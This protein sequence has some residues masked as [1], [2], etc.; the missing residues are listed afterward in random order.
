MSGGFSSLNTALTALRYNRVAMDVAGS[1]IA[2]VTTDGYAR[3]RVEGAAVAGPTQPALWSRY[4]GA[5]DGVQVTGVTRMTDELLNVRARREHGNQAYLD[6]RQASLENIENG[7]GEPGDSGV[8]AALADLRNA[9]HELS[10][11]PGSQSARAQVLSSA[12]SVVDAIG[13]QARNVESEAGDQRVHVLNDVSEVNTVASG[14]ADT[15]R[16]IAAGN[17][18]GSDVGVLLDKRDQLTQRL[19]E[20]TGAKATVRSDGGADVTINGVP[21]VTG[22]RAGSLTVASGITP[23]GESDGTALTF[24]V[25]DASGATT[26]PSG[27]SGEIGGL[28]DLLTTT[29]PAYLTGLAAV[30]K[31]L[32]DT[33]NTQHQAGYDAAGTAGTAMF[34]YDPTDVL[35]TLSVAISDPDLVA[36]S[37]VPGGGL[38]V[39]NANALA[40]GPGVEGDYQRLVTGLG[41]EV[42]ESRRRAANQ[43]VLTSQVDGAREQ[44]SGVDLDEEMV[45]MISAQRAYESASRVMTTVDSML[46]TLINRT[47][48]R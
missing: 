46:D 7:L 25:V 39:G 47:G 21:L 30:A 48:V 2:N 20:L 15:N 41:T 38:D 29:L 34:A 12:R 13:V 23:D 14:L 44:L 1:N 32:A 37:S 36:A 3:R 22:S 28:T 9:W 4:D 43:Q 40:T 31:D 10:L 16:A 33:V 42:V 19:A 45:N 35:G 26:V 8:N 6:V 17:L 11:S 5:G 24:A 18:G 27:M